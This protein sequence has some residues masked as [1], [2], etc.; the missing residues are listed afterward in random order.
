[1]QA[2]RNDHQQFQE[3]ARIQQSMEIHLGLRA[4]AKQIEGN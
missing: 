3:Q 4:Q 2:Q 1:M